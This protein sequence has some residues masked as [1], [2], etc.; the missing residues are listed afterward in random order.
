[1]VALKFDEF[2]LFLSPTLTEEA[3]REVVVD[4][5]MECLKDGN[6]RKFHSSAYHKF[7]HTLFDHKKAK[8]DAE[9]L[10]V[11]SSFIA[12]N[13]S[14]CRFDML[15]TKEVAGDGIYIPATDDEVMK[16]E[17]LI[18]HKSSLHYVLDNNHTAVCNSNDDTFGQE[19]MPIDCE[20]FL[21]VFKVPKVYSLY[22]SQFAAYDYEM[23][24]DTTALQQKH[25]G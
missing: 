1:M 25:G 18:D 5:L 23:I 2:V 4:T 13:I 8:W 22:S 9:M 19:F 21:R 3:L 14:G 15:C 6:A 17:D 20:D 10:P 11:V 24:S 7:I 12:V 16:A